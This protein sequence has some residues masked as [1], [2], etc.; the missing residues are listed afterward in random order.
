MN[1]RVRWL[2]AG[3]FLPSP[4]GE[5]FPGTADSFAERLGRAARGLS[6]AVPDRI[7]SGGA[8]AVRAVSI[9]ALHDFTLDA[10]AGASADLRALLAV[11]EAL[12][13]G[14]LYGAGEAAGLKSIQDSGR[15]A[16]ALAEAL[17]D[18]RSP[19]DAR[20][21]ALA[22]LEEALFA[23]ARDV[24]QH[25]TVAGLESAWRGLHWLQE[26]C[27]PS[28]GIDL[29]I[30]D[31]APRQLLDALA[32]CLDSDPL[33]RPD[34]CFI[35]DPCDDLE[36]LQQLAV[37]GEQS[38]LPTVVALPPSLANQ[39]EANPTEEW[40]RLR[41]H[42]SSRW[43]CATLNPVVAMVE[44]RGAVR[45]ECFT[46]P[47][48]AV[49]VLLAASL[50]DTG[51]FARAVGPGSP[52]RAPSAWPAREGSTVAT[53]AHLSLRELERLAAR[54]IAGVSG[55]WDSDAVQAVA[56]PTVY[57]GRDSAP[58]PAQVL[59]GRLVR[60]IQE[61][62]GKLPAGAGPEAV[63]SLFSRAAEVFIP[64]GPQG[65]CR[66]QAKMMS[67]AGGAR[68]VQVRAWLRPELAGTPLQLEL[69]ISLES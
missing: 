4:S 10:V 22:V 60:L 7:G 45:R 51:T 68:A 69:A 17:R 1:A 11:Y 27:P 55:W 57:G 2:V 24:L 20:R 43:L 28:S 38:F 67:G 47:V 49:A 29:E 53:Q 18:V 21:A 16:A 64:S 5:R 32:R 19:A 8:D 13:G 48:L 59:T 3:A 50:R 33:Q 41:G 61:L 65:G 46:S 31:V 12:S 40:T 15:L 39:A 36:T 23:T 63:T 52:T 54:G 25:P 37:L 26:Y 14:G 30:L 62:A 6:V 9:R 35:L 56:L 42:E 34:A 44:H 58:L 66:L